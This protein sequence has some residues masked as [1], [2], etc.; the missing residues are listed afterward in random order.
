MLLGKPNAAGG[1][2]DVCVD[3]TAVSS[4]REFVESKQIIN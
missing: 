3:E 2:E 4:P 1:S